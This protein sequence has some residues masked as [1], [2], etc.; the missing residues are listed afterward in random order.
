[1]KVSN[2]NNKISKLLTLFYLFTVIGEFW[3]VM[4]IP[5]T[6]IGVEVDV[7]VTTLGQFQNIDKITKNSTN[8]TDSCFNSKLPIHSRAVRVDHFDSTY[9]RIE[10]HVVYKAALE[11]QLNLLNCR[12]NVDDNARGLTGFTYM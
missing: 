12:D 9:P 11:L 10:L 6:L 2:N 1:M 3:F 7:A 8:F 4:S 5:I